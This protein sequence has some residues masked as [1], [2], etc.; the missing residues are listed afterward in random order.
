[1]AQPPEHLANLATDLRLAEES[2]EGLPGRPG[3]LPEQ[4]PKESLWG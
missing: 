1:V 3:Q 4:V 2:P